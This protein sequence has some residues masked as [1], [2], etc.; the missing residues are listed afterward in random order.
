MVRLGAV[1]SSAP[2]TEQ[3]TCRPAVLNGSCAAFS[4]VARRS[5]VKGSQPGCPCLSDELMDIEQHWAAV[6]RTSA[7]EVVSM[8]SSSLSMTLLR[9]S[10]NASTSDPRFMSRQETTRAKYPARV[11][12]R[13]FGLSRKLNSFSRSS[14]SCMSTLYISF[15][16]QQSTSQ[17]LNAFFMCCFS[18]VP[19]CKH[20][21]SVWNHAQGRTG[22]AMFSAIFHDVAGMLLIS[23]TGRN[24][25]VI[26]R[27]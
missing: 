4:A 24:K 25:K 6:R 17:D 19:A 2:A 21:H 23:V 14:S 27:S 13:G 16:S 22:H 12:F 18:F 7:A 11:K 8:W 26:V 15:T 1:L 5:A 20:T 10:R 9:P 3:S